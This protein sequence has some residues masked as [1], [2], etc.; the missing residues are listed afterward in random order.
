[1]KKQTKHVRKGWLNLID[2]D[3]KTELQST[4]DAIFDGLVC[5][6]HHQEATRN[7]SN[8]NYFLPILAECGRTAFVGPKKD[9]TIM[10]RKLASSLL[11]SRKR[12][13]ISLSKE[14]LN[15]FNA[16]WS[17]SLVPAPASQLSQR[18]H[19]LLHSGV[20]QEWDVISTSVATLGSKIES[21]VIQEESKKPKI[22]H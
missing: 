6:Q 21:A 8:H 5:P 22:Y 20:L 13:Q 14:F 9:V 10:F 7:F 12:Q 3:G 15:S 1:M 16:I 2:W 19:S 11:G 18:V 4:L 17:F